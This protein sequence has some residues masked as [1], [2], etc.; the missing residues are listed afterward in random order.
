[1]TDIIQK[2]SFFVFGCIVTDTVKTG[3]MI[4]SIVDMITALWTVIPVNTIKSLKSLIEEII[5]YR[6]GNIMD[7]KNIYFIRWFECNNVMPQLFAAFLFSKFGS[8]D[9]SSSKLSVKYGSVAVI[10]S[11]DIR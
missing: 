2:V 8:N 4:D 6:I 9:N 10:V 7:A 1:M 5:T 11:F 3:N